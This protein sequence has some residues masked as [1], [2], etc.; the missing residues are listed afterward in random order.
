MIN[1]LVGKPFLWF[2]FTQLSRGKAFVSSLLC[3]S[4]S[5]FSKRRCLT[6]PSS[7]RQRK[8]PVPTVTLVTSVPFGTSQNT[9][10]PV[11]TV[12]LV[13][14]VPFGTLQ[15]KK[16]PV[17]TVTLVTSVPFGTLQHKK[18]PVPT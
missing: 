4:C 7:P 10:R 11:P 2:S 17:P 15:H 6:I 5:L 12:T 14:S 3:S 9:K 1:W 8:R 18:R 16:R 13:T